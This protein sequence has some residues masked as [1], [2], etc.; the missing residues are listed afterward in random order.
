MNITSFFQGIKDKFFS[1][2]KKVASVIVTA[3]ILVAIPVTYSLVSQQQDLRQRAA[4]VSTPPPYPTPPSQLYYC[5]ACTGRCVYIGNQISQ[6]SYECDIDGSGIKVSMPGYISSTATGAPVTGTVCYETTNSQ[7]QSCS[8]CQA[9]IPPT[10]TPTVTPTPTRTALPSFTPTPTPSITCLTPVECAAPPLNCTYSGAT[11]SSCG[12]LVCASPTPSPLVTPSPSPLPTPTPSPIPSPNVSPIPGSTKISFAFSL[13]GI[14]TDSAKGENN[15]P[16]HASTTI[17]FALVNPALGNPFGT[18][19]EAVYNTTTGFYEVSDEKTVNT[20]GAYALKVRTIASLWKQFGG[21]L[22]IAPNVSATA[23][24]AVLTSGD[25]NQDNITDL[26][27][28]NIML[29]CINKP[30]DDPSCKAQ[31]YT[32]KTYNVSDLNDDGVVDAKDFN[33]LLRS[34]TIRSG[35]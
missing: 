33:I 31:D 8:T 11:C 18:F 23:P 3:F 35:D 24:A 15:S 12:T 5:G 27:D 29:S 4:E 20:P 19:S 14:G 17:Q 10:A 32:G 9:S 1:S 2:P 28:Y 22:N 7:G 21:Y 6:C 26:T 34:F 25:L 30:F 16:K 13:P